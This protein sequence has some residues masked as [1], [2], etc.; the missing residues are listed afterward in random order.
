MNDRLLSLCMIVRD[1]EKRL[2]RCLDSVQHAVD[3]IIIVDTGSSD[4]TIEIARSYGAKVLRREWTESFADARNESIR[5][6]SGQWI[7]WMDADEVLREGDGEKLRMYVQ[8]SEEDVLLLE[9]F[10]YYGDGEADESQVYMLAHHRLF[11]NRRG[12]SF[13]HAI[14]EQLTSEEVVLSQSEL[15]LLPIRVYHFGYLE[16]VAAEKRKFERNMKLLQKEK[17]S[18]SDNLWMDYHIA[19]EYYRVGQYK[20]AFRHTNAAILRFLAG[21]KLPPSVFYHMKY[22]I[23]TATG[24]YSGAWPGIEKAIALYP[25]YV[26]LH[27]Y[28]GVILY[29]GKRYAE[30]LE[31]FRHCLKLGDSCNLH[32]NKRGAGSFY[33]QYYIGRCYE[34]MGAEELARAAYLLAV[35]Q[36]PAFGEAKERLNELE[37][38][39]ERCLKPT[40]PI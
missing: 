32:L 36:Y 19:G 30:A 1:E 33:S 22:A 9:L 21:G 34:E 29:M 16:E 6:A 40:F 31:T 5:E 14:H 38:G 39:D 27:F 13:V 12:F 28:K 10:N 11:R 26:D 8:Q 20:D 35:A 7:L 25:E 37:R 2:G 4:R 23:L 15:K 17:A 24:S 3:E 18:N